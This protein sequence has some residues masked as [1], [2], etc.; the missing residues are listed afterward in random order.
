MNPKIGEVWLADLGMTAKTRPIIIVSRHDP[1]P[2]RSLAI[3]VSLTTQN[4]GSLYKVVLPRL[5]FLERDS[6]A[7]AL[8]LR[9]LGRASLSPFSG[10]LLQNYV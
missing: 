2:P 3:Y 4:R 1:D 8:E 6:I 5:Q 9:F 7:T 10:Q